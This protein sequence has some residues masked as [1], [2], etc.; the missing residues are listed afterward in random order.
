MDLS[1]YMDLCPRCSKGIVPYQTGNCSDIALTFN[2]FN[3][4]R[5]SYQTSVNKGIVKLLSMNVLCKFMQIRFSCLLKETL[6]S[7]LIS[8]KLI[9][10]VPKIINVDLSSSDKE[11][12]QTIRKYLLFS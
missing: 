11:I 7:D 10:R 6:V 1:Q 9:I 8:N 4:Q 12:E 2:C 3:C 5:F